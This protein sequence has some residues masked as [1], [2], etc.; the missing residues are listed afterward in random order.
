MAVIKFSGI[1]TTTINPATTDYAVS[2]LSG[3]TDTLVTY[4]QIATTVS[5]IITLVSSQIPT[6]NINASSV[7]AGNLSVSSV[8]ATN[9]GTA[10][11][12]S[13]GVGSATTGFYSSG[14]TGFGVSVNSV[15]AVDFGITSTSQWSFINGITAGSIRANN[16]VFVGGGDIILTRGAAANLRL[17]GNVTASPTAQTL[18]V[19]SASG[20]NN[21]GKDFTIVGS[22]G[23]GNTTSGNIVLQIS[24]GAGSSSSTPQVATTAMTISASTRKVVHT[25]PITFSLYTVTT[26]NAISGSATGDVAVVTDALAPSALGTLTGGGTVVCMVLYTG[27]AWEAIT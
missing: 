4:S 3:S 14:S 10:S 18:S 8:T 19:Q 20:V 27:G 15:T 24:S 16:T 17:G 6:I 2:V 22:L 1:T 5:P 7:T 25:A 13:V 21:P 12:P 23:T 11:S 9:S 26:L